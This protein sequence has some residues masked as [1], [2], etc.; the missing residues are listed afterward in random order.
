MPV[1]QELRRWGPSIDRYFCVGVVVRWCQ[2]V[3]VSFIRVHDYAML[4][5]R[6]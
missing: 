5:L 1:L 3:R 6:F 4:T 2:E